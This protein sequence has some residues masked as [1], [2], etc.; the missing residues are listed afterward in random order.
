[1]R[2]HVVARGVVGG[3]WALAGQE[4]L[5]DSQPGV[6][7]PKT[8]GERRLAGA[9]SDCAIAFICQQSPKR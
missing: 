3:G 6:G 8:V 1:M 4:S 9:M 5:G 7:P 2:R